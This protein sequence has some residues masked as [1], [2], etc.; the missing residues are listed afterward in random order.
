MLQ[1]TTMGIKGF[2]GVPDQIVPLK[3]SYGIEVAFGWDSLNILTIEY[4]IPL[5]LILGHHLAPTDTIKHMQL[6]F[7]ENAMD[8]PKK[9]S[10]EGSENDASS[11]GRGGNSG[12]GGSGMGG[13]GGGGMG[14][15]GGGMGGGRGGGGQHSMQDVNPMAQEQKLWLKIFL[16]YNYM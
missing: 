16:T 4:K 7:V 5:S 1:Q 2:A 9:E 13:M 11:S 12:M 8:V 15:R 14:G 3:N 10:S 6:G